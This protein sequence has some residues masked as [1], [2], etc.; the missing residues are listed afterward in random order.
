MQAVATWIRECDEANFQRVFDAYPDFRFWNARTESVP[1]EIA[2][3]LLTGGSDIS[4]KFLRQPVPDPKLIE[5]AN[6]ERDAWEFPALE[7][8]M[9]ARR[10]ILAICR[11]LQVMNV[12]LGG[13][14]HLDIPKHD[15]F[16]YLNVQPV[17]YAPDATVRFAKVNSSHH[18]A[19]D[20]LGTGL[21]VEGRSAEDGV[22]EQARLLDYP[23]ALGAQFHPERDEIYRSFFDVF[24]AELRRNASA[25]S[26]D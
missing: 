6:P 20:R 12:T 2:G 1:E 8:A 23:F 15:D 14:L 3:L 26:V 7:R 5:D 19:L 10:P 13:T 17:D 4:E 21:K 18:Q 11:G 25:K 9:R 24:I 16:K 22:I